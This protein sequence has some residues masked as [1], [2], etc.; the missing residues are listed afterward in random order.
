MGNRVTQLAN[1]C[2]DVADQ[3]FLLTL[4]EPKASKPV[5]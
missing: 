2:E 1:E 3:I 4:D 5:V